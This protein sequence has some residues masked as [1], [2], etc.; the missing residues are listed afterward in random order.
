MVRKMNELARFNLFL[1]DVIRNIYKNQV[2]SLKYQGGTSRVSGFCIVFGEKHVQF[3]RQNS[4]IILFIEHIE[5]FNHGWHEY[6][7]EV[8]R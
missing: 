7:D 6:R 3:S 2:G 5:R 1:D 8:I 4:V